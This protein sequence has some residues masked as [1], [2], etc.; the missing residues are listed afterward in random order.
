[1]VTT[2]TW[3]E[4]L[5]MVDD[6]GGTP[7]LHAGNSNEGTVC[8][9]TETLRKRVSLWVEE[10]EARVDGDVPR[11][12]WL[13]IVQGTP[14]SDRLVPQSLNYRIKLHEDRGPDQL[15]CPKIDGTLCHLTG[16][17]TSE[18]YPSSLPIS[19]VDGIGGVQAA[20]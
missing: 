13:S 1:M 11:F 15:S 5:T 12:R 19:I 10:A 8:S 14:Y 20:L 3:D 7:A 9:E 2:G 6:I 17:S 16:P 18:Q 4:A